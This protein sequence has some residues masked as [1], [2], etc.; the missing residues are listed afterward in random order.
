MW[1]CFLNNIKVSFF[2][3]IVGFG[4]VLATLSNAYDEAFL[5]K[6]VTGRS[7]RSEMFFKMATAKTWTW[8]LDPGAEKPGP[9]KT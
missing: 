9:R 2:K 6:H 5:Q 7:S 4:E 1:L 8:T 3:M